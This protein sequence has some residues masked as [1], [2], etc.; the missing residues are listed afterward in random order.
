MTK[1]NQ[2]AAL[3]VSYIPKDWALHF[4]AERNRW[5]YF[6]FIDRP[7]YS[8]SWKDDSRK[9]SPEKELRLKAYELNNI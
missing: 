7:E 2:D 1:A 8:P 6:F 9:G 5:K 3:L 4:H